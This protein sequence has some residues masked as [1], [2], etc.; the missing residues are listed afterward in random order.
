M[1]NKQPTQ[2]TVTTRPAPT[3]ALSETQIRKLLAEGR[4]VDPADAAAR[5]R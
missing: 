2:E 1:K 4:E 5:A 3:K